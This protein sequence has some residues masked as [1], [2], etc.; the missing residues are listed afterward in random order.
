MIPPVSYQGAKQ[1]IEHQICMVFNRTNRPEFYDLCCG[2]GTISIGLVNRG[3]YKPS[4]ITMVDAGPWGMFWKAIGEGSFSLLKFEEY[5]NKIPKDRGLIKQHN[6]QLILESPN[7]YNFLILQAST[8]GG[9]AIC[10][11][12]SRY[13]CSSFR[14][15]WTPTATSSRQSPVNPM[16]PMPETLFD[17]VKT[18]VAKMI[19]IK[20]IFGQ[21][22]SILV[23]NNALV[24]IDPPYSNT[25]GY[26][27]YLDAV[28]F[29]KRTNC[30]T[31]IS[32]GRALSENSILISSGRTK[33]GMLGDR[34]KAA[35]EEWLSVFN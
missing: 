26:G 17:R 35:N 5:C 24:Y 13:A 19:G 7:P 4:I 11:N 22:E 14:S 32:E 29:A 28:A 8:F 3:Y 2:S 23:P 15:Y 27:C 10:L 21:V 9:K 6:E 31:Y 30:K 34:V 20:G 25:T 1:R 16:M 12:G 18:I 33:G